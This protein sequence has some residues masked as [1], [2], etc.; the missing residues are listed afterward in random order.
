MNRRITVILALAGLI[1]AG[2]VALTPTSV[3]ANPPPHCGHGNF[4]AC[5][6]AT[7]APTATEWP[8]PT[9]RGFD[10][11]TLCHASPTGEGNSGPAKSYELIT[12][13]NQGQL[14]GHLGHP[15][16]IVPAESCP[17][18][19]IDTP[20]QE[21]TN[22]PTPTETEEP[23]ATPTDEPGPTATDEPSATPTN[24]P[25]CE[26]LQDCDGPSCEELQNCE[27]EEPTP[28]SEPSPTPTEPGPTETSTPEPTEPPVVSDSTPEPECNVEVI[29]QWFVLYGP[30]GEIEKLASY[31][32]NPNTGTWSIPN[33]GAQQKCLGYIAIRA[34]GDDLIYRDCSGHVNILCRKCAG[35]GPSDAYIEE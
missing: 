35:G 11:V 27:T 1:C 16:D 33:V 2:V 8:T 26:E 34:V 7:P 29:G 28:T 23:T 18:I 9:Q 14:N 4:P 22:E 15:N 5:A 3:Q 32:L 24:E 30:N 21:P 6:T 31:Q 12:V 19:P 20:T 17:V 25:S 13:D 10:P